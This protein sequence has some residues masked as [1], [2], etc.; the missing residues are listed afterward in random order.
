MSWRV[1]FSDGGSKTWISCWWISPDVVRL[2]ELDWTL[3]CDNS[4][5]GHRQV[6]G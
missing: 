2:G 3:R 5:L 6:G 1:F 4:G